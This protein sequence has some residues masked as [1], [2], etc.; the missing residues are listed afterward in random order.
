M[1]ARDKASFAVQSITE[2][3]LTA[4]GLPNSINEMIEATMKGLSVP[5]QERNIWTTFIR[6]LSHTLPWIP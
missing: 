5:M 6:S 1:L 4:A 3:D 2:G